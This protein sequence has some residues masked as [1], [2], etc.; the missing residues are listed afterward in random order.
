MIGLLFAV[1]LHFPVGGEGPLFNVPPFQAWN[2]QA[3]TNAS[4]HI[5]WAIA[6]PLVGERIDGRRGLWVA[7]GA[8]VAGT[9]L[10]E[11]FAHPFPARGGGPEAR[12]DLVTRL[13]PTL[14][15]LAWDLWRHR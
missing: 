2:E 13:V 6:I 11:S 7:G 10:Q 3:V 12:T 15:I 4:A 14:M 1:A 9:V 8:W 5:G